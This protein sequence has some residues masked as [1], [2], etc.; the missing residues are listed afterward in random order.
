MEFEKV[1]LFDGTNL[2]SWTK[3]KDGS[4]AEWIIGEDGAMTVNN[5]DIVSTQ[6]FKDAHIHVEFWLPYMPECKGQA[7]ANSGV[8]V[9]GCYEV[10]VL[11]S[12]GV[13]NIKTNDCAG[14]YQQ[15][16]PMVNAN[17]K[18]EEWQTYDIYF[19]APRYNEAGEIIEDARM[20]V[21]FNG[22]CVH[23]NI[24][25]P[26][27]T[28]GGV[29]PDRVP[30]GPLMLQDHHNPVRYRNVYFERLEQLV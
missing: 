9:H 12:Y 3:K 25:L 11:D 15:Y 7:R 28:P 21:I 8:Y 29:N 4:P 30:E 22:I 14:I 1:V 10:Q 23:N 2:D 18:P 27:A 24:T 19:R 13:Q 5:G 26:A 17:K 6:T 20:T 16:K